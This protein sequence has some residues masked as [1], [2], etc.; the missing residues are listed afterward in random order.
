MVN[1]KVLLCIKTK[2]DKNVLIKLIFILLSINND[3]YIRDYKLLLN[4]FNKLKLLG[5]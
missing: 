2:G 5:K 1:I 3:V 4:V